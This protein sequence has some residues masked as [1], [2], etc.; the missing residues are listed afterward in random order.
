MYFI[1]QEISLCNAAFD[2][3]LESLKCVLEAEVFVDYTTSVRL[4]HQNSNSWIFLVFSVQ[5]FFILGQ[6]Q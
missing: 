3:D 6:T 2:G 5:L 4:D 1:F